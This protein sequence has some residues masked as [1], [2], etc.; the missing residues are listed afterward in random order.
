M[1]EILFIYTPC[2][3]Y[4]MNHC[5]REVLTFGPKINVSCFSRVIV[6]LILIRVFPVSSSFCRDHLRRELPG[7]RLEVRG[8]RSTGAPSAEAVENS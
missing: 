4:E 2:S 5:L 8:H 3:R 6:Y 1:N 7:L